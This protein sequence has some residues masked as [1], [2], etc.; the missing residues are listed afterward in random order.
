MPK[1]VDNYSRPVNVSRG[2]AALWVTNVAAPYR[3]PV[4]RHLAMRHALTVGLLESNAG[5]QGDSAANRGRDWLHQSSDEIVFSELPSWKYSRGESRHYVLKSLRPLLAVRKFDTI[6]FG[7]WESPAYWSL[8]L[9]ATLFRVARVG[10]Y[11]SPANTMTYRSGV[12]AWMRSK[13]F[14]S[15]D[16]VVVPGEAAAGAMLGL[17]VDP[18]RI[19]RGFNA[20]DVRE[21]HRAAF[22]QSHDDLV[23]ARSGHRF[24]YVG[25]LIPRKRV[26][27]II[28]AFVRMA[29]PDDELTIVGTGALREDLQ[30]LADGCEPRI[31]FLEH[32][33][34]SDMPA[35]MARHHTLVLA[36]EREVWGLVV[37][38]ALATGMHV[39]VT[40][41]CGVVP[42]VRG[43][44]GV[45]VAEMNLIDLTLQMR[46]SRAAWKGR[47]AEPEILQH[48]PERFAEVFDSAFTASVR[49]RRQANS[50]TDEK[51]DLRS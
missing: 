25:Q 5:L 38:E 47:I 23:G 31:E 13:F 27:A 37:N 29:A 49:A 16:F 41:N 36:S 43:M 17:G 21:F 42:S 24:L 20:V 32:T 14:R 7:G 22:S 34:N 4:W 39:V 11:E 9:S 8:L 46:I 51:E 19:L 15:M 33:N 2:L 26:E 30:L 40:D 50:K 18:S 35:V 45:H 12:I 1:V 28:Q 10:F 3:I 48:T 44:Q 6:L